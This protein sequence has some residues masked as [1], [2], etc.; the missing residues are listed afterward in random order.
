ML[1]ECAAKEVIEFNWTTAKGPFKWSAYKHLI[2]WREQK[3]NLFPL[4]PDT[5][6]EKMGFIVDLHGLQN[7]PQ[8]SGPNGLAPHQQCGTNWFLIIWNWCIYTIWTNYTWIH[9]THEDQSDS[10][11]TSNLWLVPNK[12]CNCKSNSGSNQSYKE[13]CPKCE[14]R[15]L[16]IWSSQLLM[17]T[18]KKDSD[19]FNM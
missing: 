11:F 15:K 4:N 19:P 18:D 5:F 1:Q 6:R 12:N 9:S 17:W 8:T 3:H 7:L 10:F 2:Y 16:N 14:K 13:N